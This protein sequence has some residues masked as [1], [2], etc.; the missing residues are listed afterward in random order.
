MTYIH[1]LLDIDRIDVPPGSYLHSTGGVF[2]VFDEQSQ[3]SGNVS[4]GVNLE[5]ER[6]FIKT[7]GY[8]DDS[9]SNLSHRQRVAYLLNAVSLARSCNHPVLPEMHRIVQSPDGPML[10]Y[11][12]T[13]G[14]LL[15]VSRMERQ[16]PLSAYKRFI[17]LP[18]DRIIDVLDAIYELHVQ[19]VELGWIVVDFYDGCLI[20]DFDNDWLHVVDLDMYHRGPFVNAMGRMFGSSRFMAPEEFVLN[21]QIDVRTTAYTMGRT[22]AVLLSDGTLSRATFRGTD[23]AFAVITRACAEAPEDRYASMTDFYNAWREARKYG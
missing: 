3:D 11:A 20:Y 15:H 10:V 9:T 16:N 21:A 6:Y 1:P 12:W 22:A 17:Q 4:Y 2:V 19:L 14:E 7:A 13:P 23:K 18:V 5:G 8:P